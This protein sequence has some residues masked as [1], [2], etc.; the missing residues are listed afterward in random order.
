MRALSQN[1]RA[2][3]QW[4]PGKWF[5]MPWTKYTIMVLYI[6][7]H[8]QYISAIQWYPV[9]V[10]GD[11]LPTPW[12]ACHFIMVPSQKPCLCKYVTILQCI[13]HWAIWLGCTWWLQALGVPVEQLV[14]TPAWWG[15]VAPE[16]AASLL[17]IAPAQL[18]EYH[19]PQCLV[20]HRWVLVHSQAGGVCGSWCTMPFC[21]TSYDLGSS[22]SF[23]MVA[24]LSWALIVW[25]LMVWFGS[26]DISLFAV[27]LWCSS[28][29]PAL[30][31]GS[32]GYQHI[33]TKTVWYGFIFLGAW[34]W[35][36]CATQEQKRQQFQKK[37]LHEY[38][39]I[40]Q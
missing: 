23:F 32:V 39:H 7:R 27:L 18:L 34:Q 22:A 2:W 8:Y 20:A 30:S 25:I 4:Y 29:G 6:F 11:D 13:L 14:P 16:K 37:Q 19:P 3:S 33:F 35:G 21:T 1:D 5:M 17:V 12:Y 10:H 40:I 28:F 9:L 38:S 24:S 15:F 36:H 26:R 31:W